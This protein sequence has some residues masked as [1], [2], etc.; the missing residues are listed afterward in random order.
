MTE[1]FLLEKEAAKK[2][3]IKSDRQIIAR[4]LVAFGPE[5][6]L[7]EITAPKI[8]DYRLARLTTTSPKIKKLIQPGTV[9]RELQVIRGLMRMAAGEDCGY[10]E[11]A[12]TVKMEK[13]PEGAC[14]SSPR[15]RRRGCWTNA[16]R[17]PSIPTRRTEA[18]GCTP[19]PSLPSTPGG[20]AASSSG[21]SGAGRFLPWRDPAGKD[22]G[23]EAPG[24]PDEPGRLR[25][26]V[27]PAHDRGARVSEHVPNR[28][29]PCGHQGQDP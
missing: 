4:L 11:K 3:T 7:T 2:K 5:T 18:R 6:P 23:R 19:W 9:N 10:L 27:S 22:E 12:P 1:R 16:A 8:A 25:C 13:E 24:D 14:A 15:T 21:S 28:V 26:V 17:P 29:R 20:G